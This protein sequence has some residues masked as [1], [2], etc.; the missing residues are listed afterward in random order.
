M[1]QKD[2]DSKKGQE[3]S[4]FTTATP[5]KVEEIVGRT[6]AEG[7]ATQVRVR[8][9][10]GRD[11]NKIM[12]RNVRGPV[13]IGDIIMLRETEMEASSLSKGGRGTV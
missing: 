1:A 2:T 12:R 6:G 9:L 4:L 5:S 10:A 8:I 3:N 11:S 13:R 7:G